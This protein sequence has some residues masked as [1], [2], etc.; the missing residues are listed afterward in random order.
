[1]SAAPV[2]LETLKA[3]QTANHVAPPALFI[4]TLRSIWRILFD[5]LHDGWTWLI[6][7]ED[8]VLLRLITSVLILM[9]AVMASRLTRRALQRHAQRTAGRNRLD[10]WQTR[11]LISRTRPISMVAAIGLYV[12]ATIFILAVW[13]LQTAFVSL[14]TAAGFAG[15]VIGIAA[16]N[17][18]SNLIAGFMIFYNH[19]FDI[20]D[21]V[22]IEDMQGIVVDVKPGATVIESWDGEKITY[23]NRI[24]EGSRIKNKSHQRKLRIRFPIGVDYATDIGK[25][26]E[27]LLKILHSHPEILKD[28]EPQ[29]IGMG[30]GDSALN[31]EL[32]Y[33]IMPLRA[34]V[35]LIQTWLM[36]EVQRAFAR[37][38]I[39]IPFPQRT[40]VWRFPEGDP[41]PGET[42][43]DLAY[44]PE[45]DTAPFPA[46][47]LG[48]PV[49]TTSPYAKQEQP[50]L[51]Y[52]KVWQK[53]KELLRI[54]DRRKQQQE[55]EKD[56]H[57][58]GAG[59]SGTTG[60]GEGVR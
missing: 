35:L 21:W 28:P 2:T 42:V 26:R 24:I 14:L 31:L 1:V 45:E 20:G 29:V 38:G 40:V 34:R 15:I 5:L 25:A 8:L 39:V 32:R 48:T 60:S 53:K 56:E 50:S 6:E 10:E 58:S 4:D 55:D 47:P 23:P 13:Q 59:T 54:Q 12:I 36:Q 17:S 52:E 49:D 19:P 16:S 11:A 44:D 43:S 37:E 30:F 9:A 33:W 7:G 27:I 46:P 3:A 41:P 51:W 22:E 57:G 18:L